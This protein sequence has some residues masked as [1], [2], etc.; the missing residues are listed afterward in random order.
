MNKRTLLCILIVFVC[1]FP[2][3]SST[4]ETF[5][6]SMYGQI[7]MAV[8]FDLTIL[9]EVLPF[10]LDS[11]QVKFNEDYLTIARGLRIGTYRL[12]SNNTDVTMVVSHTP[13]RL[14]NNEVT[15]HN[16]INYRLYVMTEIGSPGFWSTTGN[17]IEISGPSLTSGGMINLIDKYLYVTL[18]EGSSNNTTNVLGAL[19]S[20]TY[21]STVTFEIWVA[22]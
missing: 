15:E 17:R 13:L 10:D 22:R 20:G 11:A 19:V 7:R 9:E 5:P 12:S 2:L 4:T 18:D 3:F 8:N 16:Q 6:H 14:R 21:E 1:L